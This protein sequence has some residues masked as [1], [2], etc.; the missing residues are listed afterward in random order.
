MTGVEWQETRA[1]E[2]KPFRIQDFCRS[3]GISEASLP[4][5]ADL[6]VFAGRKAMESMHVFLGHELER[7]HG[8]VLLGSAFIDPGESR[9]YV[10]IHAAVPA[11]NTEGS[12]NHL[13]FTPEAWAYISGIIDENYPDLVV[14][15]W[16]HSHPGLGVF[17]SN[18][19]QATQRAFFANSWNLA[20]VSDPVT[21]Q[22]GWFAGPDC[23]PLERGDVIVYEEMGRGDQEMAQPATEIESMNF[24]EYERP[25]SWGWLLPYGLLLLG[26]L[27]F[28]WSRRKSI[29]SG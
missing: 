11:L 12:S 18:T 29:D 25:L 20:V 4:P 22:T 14:V 27:A 19:D 10:V 7:E 24:H 28:T 17:M 5:G 13:Q 6:L 16:Y 1:F 3:Q 26:M 9:P 2:P 21:L 15:G 23:I 8:G